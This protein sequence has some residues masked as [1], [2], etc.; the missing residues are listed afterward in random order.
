MEMEELYSQLSDFAR[1]VLKP[2]QPGVIEIS[3]DGGLVV[4]PA[5]ALVDGKNELTFK[6]INTKALV[7][8]PEGIVVRSSNVCWGRKVRQILTGRKLPDGNLSQALL[9][10]LRHKTTGWTGITVLSSAP[11]RASPPHCSAKKKGDRFLRRH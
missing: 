4:N 2:T 1:T 11:I 7:F 8:L 6:A 10:P 9:G 3:Y 5:K